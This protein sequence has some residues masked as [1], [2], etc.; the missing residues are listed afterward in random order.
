[1]LIIP[2]LKEI[3]LTTLLQGSQS[4]QQIKLQAIRSL[5]M[6]KICHRRISDPLSGS[7]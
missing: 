4:R 1:M 6:Y 7:M 3:P 5:K 2:E